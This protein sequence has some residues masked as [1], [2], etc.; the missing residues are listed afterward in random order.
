[1]TPADFFISNHYIPTKGHK[2]VVQ[3]KMSLKAVIVPDIATCK[4][5]SI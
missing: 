3:S 4:L 1:M 2:G 5:V